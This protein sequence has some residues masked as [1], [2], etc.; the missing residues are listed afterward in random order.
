M[1]K[2]TKVLHAHR[3]FK[4]DSLCGFRALLSEVFKLPRLSREIESEASEVLHIPPGIIII[5]FKI[6]HDDKFTKRDFRPAQ[7]FVQN[8]QTLSLP[9]QTTSKTTSDFNPGLPTFYQRPDSA[10]VATRMEKSV[11]CRA[12]VTENDVLIFN[13]SP[14]CHACHMKWT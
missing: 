14:K 6:K 5:R 12:R 3:N 2:V 4:N 11:R 9:P 10:T 13:M 1:H 7:N 8:H